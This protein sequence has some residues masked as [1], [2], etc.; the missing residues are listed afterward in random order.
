MPEDIALLKEMMIKNEL[1]QGQLDEFRDKSP[2][3]GIRWY[4]AGGNTIHLDRPIG[5]YTQVILRKYGDKGVI[6]YNAWQRVVNSESV[7]YGVLVR[8]DDV[9]HEMKI[10]GNLAQPEQDTN[11]NAFTE[12]QLERIITGKIE[13][14][15]K[16]LKG[17]TFHFLPGRMLKMVDRLDIND[18]NKK[19]IMKERFDYL[20]V[21]FRYKLL[22]PHDLTLAC[23]LNDLPFENISVENMIS[24]LTDYDLANN[25]ILG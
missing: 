9:I 3:V 10:I 15:K 5:G 7:M 8:D 25:E 23:E 17:A 18:S 14:I 22:H 2:I 24:T 6:D 12:K 21:Y 20:L 16:V 13:G 19:K 4:G 11:T 1:L